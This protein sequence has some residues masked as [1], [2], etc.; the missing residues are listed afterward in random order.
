MRINPN[1]RGGALVCLVIAEQVSAHPRP[2]RAIDNV[3]L[4]GT[5]GVKAD[6][7]SYATGKR[8]LAAN[9][10][11]GALA[12]FQQM[13]AASPGSVDALNGIGVSYDQLGRADLARSYYEAGL[14]IDPAAP[15]LLNNFGYSLLMTGDRAAAI[16]PL[17]AAA[18]SN[19]A[20]AASAARAT[21]QLIVELATPSAASEAP[22][23]PVV[24][25]RVKLTNDGEQ[26]LVF[27]PVDSSPAAGDQAA[28][29]AVAVPWTDR[30]D[31][32]LL[33]QVQREDRAEQVAA[34]A[35]DASRRA[36]PDAQAAPPLPIAAAQVVSLDPA[37]LPAA[38]E[39][40]SLEKSEMRPAGAIVLGETR[41]D[42]ALAR[43]RAAAANRH[44]APLT[45]DDPAQGFAAVFDSDDAE[46]NAFAARMAASADSLRHRSGPSS[47]PISARFRV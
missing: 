44:A 10:A 29:A 15:R 19:D 23:V 26:R 32:A 47:G 2:V 40:P 4:V 34:L 16:V 6:D 46:L 14:A 21:L 18:A 7:D 13:L 35:A 30:D 43:R 22:A 5:V 28:L 37:S 36:E 31:A 38:D 20:E 1:L 9:D 12:A 39:T 11:A 24:A 3:R 41:A 25:A 27:G 42:A 17:R 8:L 33:A 45:G